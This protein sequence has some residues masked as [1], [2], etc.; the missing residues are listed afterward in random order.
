LFKPSRERR[1]AA[2][3]TTCIVYKRFAI[4]LRLKMP[5]LLCSHQ[6]TSSPILPVASER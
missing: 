5:S 4:K 1:I 6:T 2:P 3:Y